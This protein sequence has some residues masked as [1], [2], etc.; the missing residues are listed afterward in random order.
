MITW[1]TRFNLLALCILSPILYFFG[2]SLSARLI[3]LV[4]ADAI[5]I[6]GLIAS[7]RRKA[8]SIEC[9]LVTVVLSGLLALYLVNR[10]LDILCK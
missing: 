1:V 4:L 9:A 7:V 3:L 2:A 6:V 5:N 10:A 8:P